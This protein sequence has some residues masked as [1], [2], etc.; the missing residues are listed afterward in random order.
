MR[1][2]FVKSVSRKVRCSVKIPNLKGKIISCAIFAVIVI[3]MIAF[4]IP[5]PIRATLKFPCPGCGMTR[6]WLYVLR[7]DFYGALKMH[8]MFWSVP[9][10]F[11]YYLADGRLFGKW[12]DRVL[13]ILISAGFLLC[14][15]CKLL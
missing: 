3:A 11:F 7:L 10:L 15:L 5:C 8:A 14:W 4:K 13:L 12:V 6:A 2:V 9:L 1:S